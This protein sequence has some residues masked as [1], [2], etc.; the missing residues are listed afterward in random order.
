MTS[1][2]H[3]FL[4]WQE[5]YFVHF[6]NNIEKVLMFQDLNFQMLSQSPS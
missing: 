5:N 4:E 1:S 6:F 2:V 3:D